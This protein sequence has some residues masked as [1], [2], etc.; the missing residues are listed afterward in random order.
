MV[1]VTQSQSVLVFGERLV[2]EAEDDPAEKSRGR[3]YSEGPA[4]GKPIGLW[5]RAGAWRPYR[6]KFVRQV[7][8]QYLSRGNFPSA[9]VVEPFGLTRGWR[10]LPT[11]AALTPYNAA[12]WPLR[13]YPPPYATQLHS[14]YQTNDQMYVVYM[15]H[16]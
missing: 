7:G 5:S 2:G 15:Q 6:N 11:V 3:D 16:I 10:R 8:S 13:L 1:R 12:V 9:E 14:I 4:S